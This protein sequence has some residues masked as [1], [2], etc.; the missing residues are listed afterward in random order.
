MQRPPLKHALI[1]ALTLMLVACQR[2]PDSAFLAR[3]GPESLIDV[4][5][6]V[7]NLSVAG[8][9]EITELSRWIERDPP[10]RA[11]LYCGANDTRC[12]EAQK[13]LQLSGV[14]V[15]LV[16]SGDRTVTLVYERILARDCNPRFVEVTHDQ[17]NA[18]S[19]SYGCA[20]AANIVQHVSDKQQFVSP[21][22]SANP[23]AVG[24]VSAYNRA[25]APRAVKRPD[26]YDLSDSLVSKAA[27]GS[28]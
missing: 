28:Q 22:L 24:A 6:E 21:A 10:T 23:S 16:G 27:T 3:G 19:P 7:V 11:E 5:S 18:L 20:T 14:P 1:L 4:S 15:T 8:P 26:G 17:Y 2:P 25:T 13:A 9:K 12:T